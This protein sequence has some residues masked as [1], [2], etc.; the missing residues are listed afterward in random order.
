M[1]RSTSEMTL[2]RC[3]YV[4]LLLLA[5]AASP[6]FASRYEVLL[7]DV[8]Q[9][10]SVDGGVQVTILDA[11]DVPFSVLRTGDIILSIDGHDVSRLG[12]LAADALLSRA[13][14]VRT[15][16]KLR[17]N[18]QM[19]S[20]N[21]KA[22]A[23]PSDKGNSSALFAAT[24][25]QAPDF[26]LKDVAGNQVHLAEVEKN[27][28]VLLNFWGTWCSNCIVEMQDIKALSQDGHLPVKVIGITVA[29]KQDAL[30]RFLKRMPLPYTVVLGP[31]WREPLLQ[32]YAVST[33]HSY[34]APLS[35]LIRPG[36]TIAYVQTGSAQH[37]PTLR[38]E[39]KQVMAAR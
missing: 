13:D 31:S 27:S 3:V 17:R 24:S 37:A 19:L 5:S 21:T 34:A 10:R 30:D 35:V 7:S 36:G 14:S 39:V 6:M 15:L 33:P 28:W 12:S 1:S 38:D 4:C 32:R 26:V 23:P 20:M 8:A 18:G 16:L 25:V 9:F 29:D 22:D 11:K 2:K